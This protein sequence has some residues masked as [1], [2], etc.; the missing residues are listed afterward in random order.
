MNDVLYGALRVSALAAMIIGLSGVYPMETCARPS[1][2]PLIESMAQEADFIV[3][4]RVGQFKET[5]PKT[6]A[7]VND[8]EGTWEEFTLSID[9]TLKGT[10]QKQ[11]V[12]RPAPSHLYLQVP[13]DGDYGIFCLSKVKGGSYFIPALSGQDFV[14]L[15]AVPSEGLSAGDTGQPLHGIAQELARVLATPPAAL[16]AMS[17]TKCW[18]QDINVGFGGSQK[19]IR[20]DARSGQNMY[21][22][23]VR[24]LNRIPSD[25]CSTCLLP[26]AK[27]GDLNNRLWAIASLAAHGNGDYL[28]TVRATLLAPP[29][30]MMLPVSFIAQSLAEIKSPLLVPLMRT[31]LRS[32]DVSMRCAAARCLRHIGTEKAS[33][34]LAGI[35]LYDPDLEVRGL[36]MEGLAAITGQSRHSPSIG[37]RNSK[38]YV[39]DEATHLAFWRSWAKEHGYRK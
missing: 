30:A 19:C 36:A 29:D 39:T 2:P 5:K 9:H 32:S 20:Y 11:V 26:L 24:L 16:A 6:Q 4:G 25:T 8:D 14:M 3:V 12:V 21:S 37:I 35:A 33:E 1:G 38:T 10:A 7:V 34:P 15:P 18:L 23:T 28:E 31:L 22:E 27:S 17:G 13:G